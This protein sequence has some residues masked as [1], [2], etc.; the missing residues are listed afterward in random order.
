MFTIMVRIK[1]N[2]KYILA[3]VIL[4]AAFFVFIINRR[5]EKKAERLANDKIK[6]ELKIQSNE[7][8]IDS[9]SKIINRYE[10][11]IESLSSQTVQSNNNYNA[12]IKSF[13]N[14]VI[15]SNDSVTSY[16]SSKIKNR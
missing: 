8:V 15:V 4:I 1:E 3:A 13:R 12:K 16:I 7:H 9:L 10:I 5:Y 2:L 14:S 6:L 11:A